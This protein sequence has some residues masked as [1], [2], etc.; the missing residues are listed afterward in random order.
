[1]RHKIIYRWLEKRLK[2]E[3]RKEKNVVWALNE[4]KNWG[5][6]N[7]KVTSGLQ[8]YPVIRTKFPVF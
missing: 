2:R 1:M 3:E 6:L 5:K 8:K 4:K 7:C